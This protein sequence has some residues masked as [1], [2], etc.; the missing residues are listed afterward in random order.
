VIRN[1]GSASAGRD[2]ERALLPAALSIRLEGIVQGVGFRPYVDRMARAHRLAGWVRNGAGDVEIHVEGPA[3]DLGAF[4][5]GLTASLPPLARIDLLE[6]VPCAAQGIEG[7]AIV[8]SQDAPDRRQPISPDVATCRACESELRDPDDRRFGYPFITCTDCGP[9]FTVIETMPYDRERTSMAAF[10]QCPECLAE[11]R[12]P[13]DRR[14]HSQTN[15]CAACGPRL[16]VEGVGEDEGASVPGSE[17]DPLAT[18]THLLQRGSIVA[19]RGLGGFHLAVDATD[20]AAVARLRERKGREAK[21][22]AVMVGD[23][24]AVRALGGPT[25]T[26]EALLQG[27]ERPIVLVRTRPGAPLAPSLAPG[28]DRVGVMLAYTPLHHLLLERVGRP[29]VM[30]SGN[31]SDEPI[32]TGNDEA[33]RRLSGIADAFLFHD[34]EIVARYDDSVIRTAGERPIFLRRARGYAPLPLSLPVPTPVPLLA[35]GPHLKNTFTLAHGRDAYVSQHIGDLESLETLEHFRDALDRFRR[36]F[37]VEPRVVVRDLHPGYL[38]SRIAEELEDELGPA[39]TVQHHHAHIAA[40]MAEHG[41]TDPVV[42]LAFDGVGLGDDGTVWGAELLVADLTDYR[43]V[44]H[45]RAAPLAG[46]D[47]AARNPWRA[48]LGYRTLKTGVVGAAGTP[49]GSGWD[50]TFMDVPRNEL[51]VAQLQVQRGL[52]APLASSMGRL[53]DAAA[54]VLGVRDRSHF[55]GQAAMELEALAG[56]RPADPLPFP[57]WDEDGILIMDPVPL[58]DALDEGLARGREPG[59]MAADFHESLAEGWAE[60][61]VR[62]A[63]A[64]G[65][66]TVALGGGVFQNARLTASLGDRLEGRGLRVLGAER[67]SPNDGGVSYGQAAV[68]AARLAGAAP[69]VPPAP[70]EIG[71]RIHGRPLSGV[72]RGEE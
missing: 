31:A 15:S 10:R 42:G 14:Y 11:Y 69:S 3:A 6:A 61:A 49:E 4:R 56:D 45:L 12:T 68:A 5:E 44:G 13:G 59:E 64:E 53:F 37:R 23:L 62:A 20:E 35:V 54:A 47:L 2:P 66:D 63:A 26:E 70:K 71:S 57:I 18:A 28:L 8:A 27:L 55:E 22:L 58:L 51:R 19:I 38:S 41:R 72:R 24:E 29:L 16:W 7:F 43:R 32:A 46:G 17:A 21:P 60:A 34:R 9:R 67:L 39:M 36:L 65:L 1:A 40:V 52:N 50:R 25:P 30:T 48:A 33:R